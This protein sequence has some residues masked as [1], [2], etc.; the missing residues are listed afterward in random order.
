MFSI[1]K[2]FLLQVG[3]NAGTQVMI[4]EDHGTMF[5]PKF[6]EF[7]FNDI[8]NSTF[9]INKGYISKFATAEIDLAS[10]VADNTYHLH[11]DLEVVGQE[12]PEWGRYDQV[13]KGR[14]ISYEFA[15]SA[16][17]NLTGLVADLNNLIKGELDGRF[18]VFST[19]G[20]KIVMTAQNEFMQFAKIVIKQTWAGDSWID[21]PKVVVTGEQKTAGLE[22]FGTTSWMISHL[23]IQT[24]AA[25]N[26]YGL[27]RDG[28]PVPG[29]LYDQ[30]TFQ[31]D[32][33]RGV[34]GIDVVGGL[35]KSR[36]Q[37]TLYI[38]ND[39]TSDVLL[40]LNKVSGIRFLQRNGA[41]GGGFEELNLSGGGE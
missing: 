38:P 13:R 24:D 36:M 34:M 33:D 37:H 14:C 40:E 10:L 8:V 16:K 21:H 19:T 25:N 41:T 4:R 12:I 28:I 15:G 7:K 5:I 23:R 1:P 30:V 9:Y 11:I 22:G 35:A 26:P 3:V 18:I 6:G 29:V 31:V 20:T 2:E 17:S 32:T 27:Y 39:L